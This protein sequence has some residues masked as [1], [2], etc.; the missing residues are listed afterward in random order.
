MTKIE[1]KRKKEIQ[2]LQ[3]M[4]SIYC[5]GKHKTKNGLCKQCEEL[6]S[7]AVYRTQRCPWMETKTF[8]SACKTH[9]YSREKQEAI[10][11]VMRYAGGRMLFYHPILTIQ[12]GFIT[13]KNKIRLRRKKTNVS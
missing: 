10:K 7:Y 12:H 4:I 2:V 5:K 3:L 9:C 1:E 11:E 13:V 8:C 6:L